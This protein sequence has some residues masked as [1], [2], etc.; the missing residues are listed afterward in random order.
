MKWALKG[1][2][3]HV[4]LF[5]PPSYTHSYI[6]YLAALKES[7]PSL[8]INYTAHSHIHTYRLATTV[9]TTTTTVTTIN[10]NS[11]TKEQTNKL[12]KQTQKN[13]NAEN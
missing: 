6:V 10:T 5:S 9:T 8:I 1:G 7:C 13:G 3:F 2:N 11:W 12:S 4:L